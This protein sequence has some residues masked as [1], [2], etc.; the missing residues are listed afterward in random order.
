VKLTLNG[1]EVMFRGIIWVLKGVSLELNE[2]Q[3]VALLGANGA[4]KTTTLKAISGLLLTEEGRVTSGSI[5]L[6][7]ERIE[8]RSPEHTA[9]LGIIQCLE[10]RRM[11][12][13]LSIEQ[14]LMSGAHARTD[15]AAVKRDLE[16]V[17]DMFPPLQPLKSATSG[18]CSGGEQQMTVFGRAIMARPRI[19]L[20]DE[21]SLGLSPLAINEIYRVVKQFNEDTRTTILVVEQNA[22]I[23]LDICEYGFIMENGRVVLD[24]SS[25]KLKD[26]QDVKEFYLGLSEL[27]KKK[28]FK[29][30]KH[31]KRRKRWL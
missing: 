7:G 23:A 5:S 16:M 15:R 31:Y 13:H 10:G 18:W 9:K 27:G 1:V 21:A 19:L 28:S 3:M 6:D 14:N 8:N 25:A 4:G 20:M 26:N 24:G 2:G 12:E 29:D 22:A 30:V 11:F 17:Y